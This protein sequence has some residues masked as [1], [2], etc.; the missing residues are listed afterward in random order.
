MEHIIA[1]VVDISIS[2]SA[3]VFEDRYSGRSLAGS[4]LPDT[5]SRL[6]GRLSSSRLIV[7]ESRSGDRSISYEKFEDI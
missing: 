4:G 3:S 7:S 5:R 6:I 2:T 1:H